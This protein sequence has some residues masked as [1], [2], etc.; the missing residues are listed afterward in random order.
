MSLLTRKSPPT[1]GTHP[2]ARVNVA[3]LLC[4]TQR[5]RYE[6]VWLCFAALAVVYPNFILVN[7]V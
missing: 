1:V 4:G 3:I 7:R 5:V 2:K 6:P